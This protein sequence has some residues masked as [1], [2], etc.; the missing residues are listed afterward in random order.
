[1]PIFLD[2]AGTLIHPRVPV[3][4]SYADIA[5]RHGVG[6]S[7]EAVDR[8]FRLAWKQSPSPLHPE[9]Q[10]SPDDDRGW[11][12]GVVRKTF[13][14]V[15]GQPLP[16]DT[17]VPMF[18]ELYDHFAQPEAWTVYEEVPSA[19]DSMAGLQPLWVLSNFDR[20]LLSILSGHG[21]SSFFEGFILSSEVGASKPHPRIFQAAIKTARSPANECFHI[22]DDPACDHEGAAAAGMQVFP[23]ERP[24]TT[25]TDAVAWLNDV[26]Q[27]SGQGA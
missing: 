18:A 20:R 17:L 7:A 27:T 14:A 11:W 10:G 22:G 2:A 8:A 19:L 13:H 4:Q 16:E 6:T 12:Q 15:L 21:L 26:G 3:G 1:M 25:L 24:H 23:L 5:L 9:G